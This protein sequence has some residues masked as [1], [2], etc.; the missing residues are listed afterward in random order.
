MTTVIT[1]DKEFRGNAY[2]IKDRDVLLNYS[3]GFA[4]LANEIPNTI[5]TRFA[6]AS[7]SKTFV[8]VGI[9]QLIEAG[10]L[11]LEDTIGSILNFD[12]KQIDPNVTVRQLLNHTSGVPDYF[13]ESVMGVIG[14]VVKTSIEEANMSGDKVNIDSLEAIAF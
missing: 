12:L 11:G 3:G 2:I 8:A 13:D 1:M 14:K 5:D 7:M 10:K 6:S 9:L 4:D